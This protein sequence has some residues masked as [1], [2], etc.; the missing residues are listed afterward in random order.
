MVTR[1]ITLCNFNPNQVQSFC[2]PNPNHPSRYNH[3]AISNHN[4]P[5]SED[6]RMKQAETS[7]SLNNAQLA[8]QNQTTNPVGNRIQVPLGLLL[9]VLMKQLHKDKGKQLQELLSKLKVSTV[10]CKTCI[11]NL[12]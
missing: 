2:N 3:F 9:P 5:S 4:Y 12:P 6:L 1:L 7:Q 10:L 11:F 8:D